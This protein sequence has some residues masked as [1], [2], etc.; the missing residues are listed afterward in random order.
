MTAG[1]Q[2]TWPSRP[3]RFIV[4]FPPGGT[5]DVL[6]RLLQ[7]RLSEALGQP[8]V[9]ENR[10]GAGT[11]IG[12]DAAAKAPP[13]GYTFLNVANSFT[14]NATLLR[15]PP[16]DARRDFRGIASLGFNPHVLVVTPGFA[17]KNLAELVTA[18]RAEPGRLSYASIGNGTSPHLGGE[19][20]KLAAG[21]DIQHVP[22]RGGPPAL[23]DVMAGTVPMTFANLPEAMPL[24]REG[25]LRPVA[26]S[27]SRR[28]PLLP[29]TPTFDEEGIPGVASNSWFGIVGRAD[30]PQPIADRMHGAVTALLTDPEIAARFAGLGVD[31]RPMPREAFDEVLRS[32]FE[33]NARIVRSANISVD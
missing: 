3:V 5:S 22:Y 8:I 13:D 7:P 31:P 4:A 26:L 24:I 16:F 30:I 10:P 32:E 28:N 19:S 29:D 14:I 17:P 15:N 6:M 9:I 18:A 25:R 27:D 2:P 11:V 20:F 21:L 33:R 12:T 23:A 1:A